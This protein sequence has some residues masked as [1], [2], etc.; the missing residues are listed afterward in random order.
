MLKKKRIM[1]VF[2]KLIS[3]FSV[4]EEKLSKSIDFTG[5]SRIFCILKR[6]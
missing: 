3:E 1:V 2:L 6:F 4:A 5:I